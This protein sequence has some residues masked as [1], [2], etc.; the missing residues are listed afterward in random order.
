MTKAPASDDLHGTAVAMSY[1]FITQQCRQ[2]CPR[3]LPTTV[4]KNLVLETLSC[5]TRQ[6]RSG[7]Y[8]GPYAR[9]NGAVKQVAIVRGAVPKQVTKL[10]LPR[11]I[12][13]G[14]E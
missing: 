12:I 2:H 6:W 8:P 7:K 5:F 3:V 13:D 11:G 9:G 14:W 1:F 4:A 10:A